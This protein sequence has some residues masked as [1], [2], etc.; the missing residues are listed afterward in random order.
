MQHATLRAVP[1]CYKS[2][3]LHVIEHVLDELSLF[4][5]RG[6]KFSAHLLDSAPEYRGSIELLF[7]KPMI[8]EFM[9][10]SLKHFSESFDLK[11]QAWIL[12]ARDDAHAAFSAA[13]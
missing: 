9:C 3:I 12:L 8:S 13:A 11:A 7:R 4:S 2:A 10:L 6:R 1:I 5:H